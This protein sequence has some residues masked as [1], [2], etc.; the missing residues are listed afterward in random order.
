METPRLARLAA[1]LLAAP[2]AVLAAPT[3]SNVAAVQQ[4]DG[5]GGTEVV[6]SYDL[7]SSNGACMV[8]AF[9]STNGGASFVAAS[10]CSGAVGAGVA[11]GT[12]LEIAWPVAAQFPSATHASTVLRVIARDSAA[13]IAITNHGFET[14]DQ[15]NATLTVSH[16]TG[17]STYGAINNTSDVI[18]TLNPATSGHFD[19]VPQG[20]NVGLVFLDGPTAA[21]AGMQQT[22]GAT[23]AAN[24]R[25]TVSAWIGNI[26]EGTANFGYFNL[27][28]FPGYRVDLMAGSTIVASD[29]NS[30]NGTIPEGEFRETT[31]VADIGASHAALGQS[32]AIRLVNLNV[33]GP[34]ATPGIEVNFDDI[35]LDEAAKNESASLLVETVAP[36]AGT[37]TIAATDGS[38]PIDVPL[39]GAADA[40]SGIDFVELWYRKDAGPWT[41]SGLTI[42]GTSGSFPFDPPGAFPGDLG[43]YFFEVVAQD[44]AGNRSAAPTGSGQGST[45]YN[46][47]VPVQLDAFGIE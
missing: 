15:P 13:A 42:D 25:Y 45:V 44:T 30:L 18:G 5:S 23:L 39:A 10:G 38:A 19:S 24:R 12:G 28:G 26:D 21:E 7:A 34:P 29:N 22:L 27:L 4:P 6:V 43:E 8:D 17:W 11:P 2:S 1:A 46:A 16:P 32:L 47:T 14:N 20:S 37:L 36:T 33:S 31:F 40:G 41:N 9:V 3:V 35:R